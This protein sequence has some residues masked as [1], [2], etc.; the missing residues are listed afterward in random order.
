MRVVS[1]VLGAV[2]LVAFVTGCGPG[3]KAPELAGGEKIQVL[4]LFDRGVTA[5]TDEDMAK[6]RNQMSEWLE[7]DLAKMFTKN[8]YDFQ[9]I[10]SADEYAAAANRFLLKVKVLSYN[11]GNKGARV[12]GALVG[13]WSGAAMA[14]QAEARLAAQYELA[15]ADGTLV[16]GDMNEGSGTSDWN[17]AVRRVNLLIIK[18]TAKKIQSLYQ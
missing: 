4:A 14:Q 11:P 13:G 7:A 1:M 5:T 17:A 12:A 10:A 15:N 6:Q 2:L 18:G 16:T 9:A 3:L 8:G